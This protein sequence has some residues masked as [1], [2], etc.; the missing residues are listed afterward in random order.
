MIVVERRRIMRKKVRKN[1]KVD[2]A[3]IENNRVS[4]MKDMVNVLNDDA[5]VLSSC[6][7]RKYILDAMYLH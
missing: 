6:E 2:F 1:K 5:C 7:I 3:L 4:T